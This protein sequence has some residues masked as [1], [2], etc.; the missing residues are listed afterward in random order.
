M[1]IFREIYEDLLNL[2]S[3]PSSDG[4]PKT[5]YRRPVLRIASEYGYDARES[6]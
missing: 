1:P 6:C 2:G 3:Q 4:D 5:I